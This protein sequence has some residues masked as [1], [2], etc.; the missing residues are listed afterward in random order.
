MSL[1]TSLELEVNS[2]ATFVAK[3]LKKSEE[4]IT[5]QA[6]KQGTRQYFMVNVAD[7]TKSATLRV[8]Q[9]NQLSRLKIGKTYQFKK[10]LK[11]YGDADFLT[12]WFSELC[13]VPQINVPDKV[14]QEALS[15]A[16]ARAP[17][18]NVTPKKRKLNEALQS[19]GTKLSR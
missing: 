4:M 19:A 7:A 10:V 13:Q 17:Q 12:I 18:E 15:S 6:S 11:K 3:V 16:C 5:Y 9:K 14:Q 8:Y 2:E 1:A